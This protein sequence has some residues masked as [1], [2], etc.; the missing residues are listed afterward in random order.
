MPQGD[1]RALPVNPHSP[2]EII[3]TQDSTLPNQDVE[4][5]PTVDSNT[6]PVGSFALLGID[7]ASIHASEILVNETSKAPEHPPPIPLPNTAQTTK[8]Q[9]PVSDKT[10]QTHIP[11]GTAVT[12]NKN[13]I[14]D[15][16]NNLAN[17]KDEAFNN[18]IDT[19]NKLTLL[20][21]MKDL[22]IAS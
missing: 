7:P 1:I 9:D 17:V 8:K 18:A 14:A 11:T 4:F 10:K 3:A 6:I 2:E 22:D 5:I 16:F 21:A 13:N 15:T 12:G 19:M 20:T